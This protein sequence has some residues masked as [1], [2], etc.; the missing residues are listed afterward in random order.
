MRNGIIRGLEPEAAQ[1]LRD[2]A[3]PINA[4]AGTV[5]FEAGQTCSSLVLLSAGTVR[6]QMVSES[7]RQLLL[8]RVTPGQACVMT[9]ACLIYESHFRAEGIAETD[10]TGVAIDRAGF[11]HLLDHSDVFRR[12][13]LEAYT[14]RI[15]DLISL[16]ED[17]TFRP[18]GERIISHLH[19]LADPKGVVKTTHQQLALDLGSAREV[20]SRHL[21]KMEAAGQI[22]MTRGEIQLLSVL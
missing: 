4:S 3:R 18:M 10:I 21:K 16:F 9:V 6:V 19:S 14:S 12:Q 11:Q 8:Y 13:V 15:L 17:V 1:Y 5:L 7:G 22:S 20:V 2:H